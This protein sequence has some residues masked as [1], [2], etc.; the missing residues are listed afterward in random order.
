MSLRPMFMALAVGVLA[1]GTESDFEDQ[2]ALPEEESALYGYGYRV[3]GTLSGAIVFGVTVTLSGA[4]SATTRTSS[5]GYYSFGSLANGTYTVR[6]SAG[7][8][9]F[10]PT[11][12]AV[13]VNGSNV[14]GQEFTASVVAAGHSI[15]GALTHYGSTTGIVN[16]PINLGTNGGTLVLSTTTT[17]L[18]YYSFSGLPDG[19]YVVGPAP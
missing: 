2:N 18:G 19:T 5:T 3:S 14:S 7:W 17:A 10:T 11:S 12:R 13:S 15:S 4:R 8:Y 1:C 6:P 9:S 16:W